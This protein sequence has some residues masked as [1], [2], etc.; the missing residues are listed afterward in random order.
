MSIPLIVCASTQ[1]WD[2]TWFRKQHFTARLSQQRPVLYVEPSRSILRPPRRGT[3]PSLRNPLLTPRL[4]TLQAERLWTYTPPRGWPLWTHRRVSPRQYHSWG[5]AVRRA[6]SD[7]GFERIWLWLYNPLWIQATGSLAPE[8]VIFDLVDDLTAYE[9]GAHTRE[10]MRACVERALT[11]SDLVLTTSKLLAETHAR[12]TR[13]GKMH[14]ISNGVPADW[15]SLEIDELPAQIAA[16]PR[17]RIGFV[18]AV[19]SYLDADLLVAAA[20]AFPEGSLI[21]VGP[22]HDE[23]VAARLRAEPN[24]HLLGAWP[25][26]R[27]PE[28]IAGFDVALSPFRAGAVRRAVNPLKVYE[29]LALGKPVV[30]TPLESLRGEPIADSIRM[31]ETAAEFVRAIREELSRDNP[32][33]RMARRRAVE[34]YTWDALGQQVERVLDVAESKWRGAAGRRIE[35]A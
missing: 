20:R 8:R 12:R 9:A 22:V 28:A 19:F 24:A 13:E 32:A 18:G 15:L 31:A 2:E 29:Y 7:L 4:R 17:P 10:T 11:E 5:G 33:V 25:Q 30:S 3:P 16:L 26:A 35:R 14:V 27:V 23:A 6:A 21:V 1:Y 34:P